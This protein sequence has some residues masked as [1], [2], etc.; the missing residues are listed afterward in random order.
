VAKTRDR[1]NR[2]FLNVSTGGG[3]TLALIWPVVYDALSAGLGEHSISFCFVP[4]LAL[5]ADHV[6]RFRWNAAFQEVVCVLSMADESDKKLFIETIS[7]RVPLQKSMLV[8]LNPEC[9]VLVK[10]LVLQNQ[11]LRVGS[12]LFDEAHTY[13]DWDSFRP[14][15]DSIRDVALD[16][17]SSRIVAATATLTSEQLESFS[18]QIKVKVG[19]WKMV[20]RI[21]PHQNHFYH[22]VEERMLL[23]YTYALFAK[24]RL[25]LLVIVNSLSMMIKVHDQV[26][27]W[28]G[29]PSS[30]VCLFAGGFSDEH[31]IEVDAHFR[32]DVDRAKIM[33]A[34]T[35]YALGIDAF[36]RSVIHFGVPRNL[37]IYLQGSGR[38]GR[39]PSIA[40]AHCTIVVG[41]V[42]LRS[43]DL[44]MKQLLGSARKRPKK[45]F[46]SMAMLS[47]VFV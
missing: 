39:H 1:K 34:T 32:D 22:V 45:P 10:L 46:G 13:V 9:F 47:V 44:R 15:F 8:F 35:A 23:R 43:A 37:A 27:E 33:I 30:S 16:F 29:L 24:D 18:A 19:E 31:K 12:L 25:P 28:S 11:H 41:A 7:S 2:V 17:P 36:I 26:M 5:Q 21:E 42:G 3:K 6:C 40:E 20:I 38:A 14:E 4:L